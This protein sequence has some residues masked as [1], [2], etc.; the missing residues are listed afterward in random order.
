MKIKWFMEKS[1]A[2]MKESDI[3][4]GPENWPPLAIYSCSV[5][6]VCGFIAGLLLGM[7]AMGILW[8]L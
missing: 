3:L 8:I 1:L 7:A 2:G 6:T 4:G 5:G